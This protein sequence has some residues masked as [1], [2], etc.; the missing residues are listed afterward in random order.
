MINSIFVWFRAAHFKSDLE[1]ERTNDG[2][3]RRFGLNLDVA[4]GSGNGEIFEKIR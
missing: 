3:E 1:T 4:G 2:S